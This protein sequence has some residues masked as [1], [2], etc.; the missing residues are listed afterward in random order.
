MQEMS[1]QS[2][3]ICHLFRVSAAENSWKDRSRMFRGA[4]LLLVFSFLLIACGGI[5]LG[6]LLPA[7]LSLNPTMVTAG[8][9]SF[10]LT[11]NGKNFQSAI[12][13]INGQ[14]LETTGGSSGQLTAI[15]PQALIQ[16]PGTLMVTVVNLL[17]SGNQI[18]NQATITVQNGTPTPAL[19]ITKTHSGNF[20]QGQTG[21]TFT[22]TVSNTG[23]ASTSGMVTASEMPPSSLTVTA[24]SGAGW[25]CVITSLNCTRSDAL[26]A[27]TS[28]PTITATASVAANA[29]TTV[30]NTVSISGGGSTGGTGSDT[31]T[32]NPP[33]TPALTITKTHSGN[34]TQGQTGATF[35][36]TV[37]NSG[38][39]PTNG[40]VTATEMPPSSLTVTALSG[41]GWT[42]LMTSLN[43]TRSD[44][45]AAGSSYPTIT[46]TVSVAS[47]A[48][49]TVTNSVSI[50]G[51]GSTAG[52]GNDTVT[53][54][55]PTTPALKITKTHSGNFTQGQTGATFTITVSNTGTGPTSATV[56]AAEMPPSS[57]TVT[58]LSGTGWTCVITTMNCTRSDVLAAGS[59][60]PTITVTV[61][62]AS[63]APATI[64]NT[65]SISGGGSTGGTGSDTVTVNPPATPTLTITKTHVG[66]PTQGGTAMYN[67]TVSNS[68]AGPSSGTVTA[69]EMPPSSLTVT[70]LSG[71]GWTCV[72]TSLNCT[73]SDALAAGSSYP[74]ITVTVLVA[75]NAPAT[76]TN[77][78]SVSG[79]GSSSATASDPT[80]I[81]PSSGGT[82][83]FT[84]MGTG[85]ASATYNNNV[86]IKVVVKDTGTG[87]TSGTVKVQFNS[88]S[89]LFSPINL[90]GDPWTCD[91]VALSCTRSD[92]ISP[93]QSYPP[94]GLTFQI[95]TGAPSPLTVS[96]TVSGGGTTSNASVNV[97]T[98]VVNCSPSSGLLCGQFAIFTQGY[99]SAGPRAIAASF[100]ADGNGHITAGVVDVNSMGAPQ[101]GLTVLTASP[102]A[103]N[104][105][106]NGFGNVILNTSAGSFVFKFIQRNFGN[107]ADVIEFEPNGAAGGSGFMVQQNPAY[108]AASVSGSYAL[109][110]AGGLGGSSAG[111]QL[112]MVGAINANGACGFAAS[113]ST[114]T[115]NDG[116]S[117]STLVDFSGSLN[118][119]SC[120]TDPTTGR[121]TASF[122]SITGSPTPPFSSAN[123]VYYIFSTNFNGGATAL[124][125]LSTDQTSTTHPL[126]SGIATLQANS[127]YNTNA[128]IDC[129][130]AGN[131]SSSTGCVFG[132]SGATGG[133]ALSG[134]GHVTAGVATVTTQSNTA[135]SLKLVLDDN[136]GG[137]ISSGN[138]TATYSY[139]SDGTGVIT[140][141]SG[142]GTAFVLTGTDSGI[143][144]GTGGSVSVG[145]FVA[146]TAT[147]LSTSSAANFIAGTRFEGTAAVTN[148]LVNSTFTPSSPTPSN[149][150][151]ISGN[152]RSWN[153]TTL[154]AANTLA[155]NYATA[156]AT[157]RGTGTT[158]SGMGIEGAASFV[159]YVINSN[160][161]LLIGTTTGGG[162]GTTTP[163]LMSFQA[164]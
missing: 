155:G 73:R 54:N 10:T 114:G 121:G 59:S 133:N 149:S 160:S 131:P 113:G 150:G 128:A 57:L 104:F 23:T 80:T 95:G 75:T 126:L 40:T 146:Q 100:T 61:S 88:G 26:P 25:T 134:N 125:L 3:D 132:S 142:E 45:L 89:S 31:V 72:M 14:P 137:T 162:V 110:I 120:S 15:V 164:P 111:V 108:S 94:I 116:G 7:I 148:T 5:G 22:I 50:S 93:G 4:S 98:P 135:G 91:Q 63:N 153:S 154:Q 21:A 13:E 17:P 33:P 56:T 139:Q 118:P 109:G 86:T 44:A 1:Q 8:G 28:Y 97:S 60:Y 35:T 82:P 141:A 161:F 144:L 103:Y 52:T 143:T 68:G 92:V 20:T 55:P 136:K 2:F 112:G 66:N 105:E 36:I 81:N 74:T 37:T 84:V 140:P 79:G 51:G 117:V 85:P 158:N 124:W 159:Y 87:P 119:A 48:P 16:N 107:N 64:T 46:A 29:P 19:K 138:T 30:T 145:M 78:V 18:S 47:S 9:A 96:A 99:N 58:A 39:G 115:I 127:P 38:T 41:T 76:V 129:G 123:F 11:V 65:V 12:V 34:F 62:V 27:D 90:G 151:A 147:N 163:V 24:L 42:C 156:P 106:S 32:V 71:T 102:T 53:V 157:G 49:A 130:V 6:S 43:C 67:I 83:A 152:S 70:A 101:T 77:T 69:T 122:T